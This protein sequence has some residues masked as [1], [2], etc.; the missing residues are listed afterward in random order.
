[1]RTADWDIEH[2]CDGW[3]F[4]TFHGCCRFQQ[5]ISKQWKCLRE[6][7]DIQMCTSIARKTHGF[8]NWNILLHSYWS[9]NLVNL[10]CVVYSVCTGRTEEW[11]W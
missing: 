6:E 4:I 3:K 2:V 8:W 9:E 7:A 11:R 5:E 10:V 1:M